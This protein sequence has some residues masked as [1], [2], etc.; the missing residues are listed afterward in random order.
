MTQKI[1]FKPVRGSRWRGLNP[2]PTV[3]ETAEFR[4][5]PVN[6]GVKWAK[7]VQLGA[8]GGLTGVTEV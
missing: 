3:Y 1:D 4:D 2:R 7:M 5:A 6:T 8:L